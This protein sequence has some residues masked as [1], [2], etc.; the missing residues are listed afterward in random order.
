MLRGSIISIIGWTENEFM[1]ADQ[2]IHLLRA[3]FSTLSSIAFG[4]CNII[5]LFTAKSNSNN[6]QAQHY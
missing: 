4:G 2:H 1:Y 3:N 6:I 5:D